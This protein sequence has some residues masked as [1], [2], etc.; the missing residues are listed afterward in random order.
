MIDSAAQL[1]AHGA[2]KQSGNP[3]PF[4]GWN[5]AF[6][7]SIGVKEPG[8]LSMR[9]RCGVENLSFFG[10][11]VDHNNN[12]RRRQ[13]SGCPGTCIVDNLA[14]ACIRIVPDVSL[15]RSSSR[16]RRIVTCPVGRPPDVRTRCRHVRTTLDFA[17]SRDTRR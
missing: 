2:V 4:F 9:P 6:V 14:G 1:I 13:Q 3:F 16:R 12:R 17:K 8:S 11:I 5:A 15:T 7:F 10:R